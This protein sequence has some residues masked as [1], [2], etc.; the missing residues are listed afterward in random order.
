M[1]QEK[2][3]QILSVIA[4]GRKL[5][6]EKFGI[7]FTIPYEIARRYGIEP[8]TLVEFELRKLTHPPNVEEPGPHQD[9]SQAGGSS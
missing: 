6:G 9:E 3:R 5:K 4:R 7:F 2:P 1:S 8:G